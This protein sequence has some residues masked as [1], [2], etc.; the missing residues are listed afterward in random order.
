MTEMALTVLGPISPE[1]LGIAL[2]HEHILIDLTCWWMDPPE[3]SKKAVAWAPVSLETLGALRRDPFISRDNLVLLDPE[4]A[5]KEVSRFKWAGG[6]T[7]TDV[8]NVG[9][10]RDPWTLKRIALATGLNIIMGSG[11]YIGPS[12][13]PE[14][15]RK[16]VEEIAEEIVRDITVGVG[17][18]GIRAGLIGEIGTSDP[19]T[20]N[21]E[22]SLRGAA[23]AQRRTGTPLTI[24]PYPWAK[25]GLRILDI[26][27]EEGADLHR[28]IMSHMN[29]TLYDLDYHR[30]IARRGAYLEYDLMGME[31]YGDSLGLST[32]R[33]IES[34]AAL[35]RLIDEGYLE[36]L[37]ISQDI[38]MKMQLTAYGGWGYA[39]ILEHVLPMLRKD[40]V[41]QEQIH[42]LT[43]ENPRR[44]LTF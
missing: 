42:T 3:A 1:R 14:M 11:Y 38:C 4:L 41:T 36:K 32:P 31:F 5:L 30:A 18:T 19:I 6:G 27:A 29:P 34:V 40:G 15:E 12:H 26:L 17:D 21:E 22:K 8:T 37:L 44:A 20:P 25:E 43:V 28:V 10:G 39:H 33:D 13:P 24:H 35:K 16:S 23:R 9:I 2:P 7:I